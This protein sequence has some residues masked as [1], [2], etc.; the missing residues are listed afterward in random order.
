MDRKFEIDFF[1]LMFLAEACIYP[2]PIARAVFWRDMIDKYYDMMSNN[3]RN[4]AYEW[5]NLNSKYKEGL[6]K[7]I[8]EV[9]MFEDRYNPWNQYK[10]TVKYEGEE[11]IHDA[12]YHKGRYHINSTTS[13]QEK[14]I[15]KVELSQLPTNA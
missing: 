11:E 15:T 9:L 12:F 14:Y 7:G 8:K 3:Q 4:R 10:V 13:I 2:S 1:E 6:K 5:I